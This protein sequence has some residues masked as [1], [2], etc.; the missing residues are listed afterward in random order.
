MRR[1]AASAL[2]SLVTR[3]KQ[4]QVELLGFD[5]RCV[6]LFW[7]FLPH[8][9]DFP[10]QVCFWFVGCNI[11]HFSDGSVRQCTGFGSLMTEGCCNL[12]AEECGGV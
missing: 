8:C 2:L 4:N 9:G 11:L 6:E 5:A 3:S 12:Q 10:T 7:D 1:Q